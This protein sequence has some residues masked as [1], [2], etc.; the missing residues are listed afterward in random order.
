MKMK[1]IDGT[2]YSN[3]D[4]GIFA[5]AVRVY[6]EMIGFETEEGEEF[7]LTKD[8]IR[9]AG[10]SYWEIKEAL[11]P[12][13]WIIEETHNSN[14][15]V[16]CEYDTRAEAEYNLREIEECDKRNGEYYPNH[17]RIVEIER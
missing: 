4:K 15:L 12:K 11:S 9:M 8:E 17:Y 1:M 3:N 7:T 6:P 13:K 5:E 10:G 14:W 16:E 2:S